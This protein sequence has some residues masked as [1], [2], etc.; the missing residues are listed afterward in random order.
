MRDFKK[1]GGGGEDPSN[2]GLFLNRV[3]GFDTPLLYDL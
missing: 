2:G 1:W 3:R